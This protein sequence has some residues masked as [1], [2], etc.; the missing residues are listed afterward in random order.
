MRLE[1]APTAIRPTAP[2]DATAQL[3]QSS[4][5]VAR[6]NQGANRQIRSWHAEAL[7]IGQPVGQHIDEAS[8]KPAAGA[9]NQH[10][11]EWE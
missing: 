9:G 5:V 8:T 3:A 1:D 6:Q 2:E 7:V 11:L 4:R 10:M